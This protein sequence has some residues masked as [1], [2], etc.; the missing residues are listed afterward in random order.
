[1]IGVAVVGAGEWGPNLIRNF[2]EHPRSEVIW[3]VDRDERRLERLGERYPGVRLSTELSEA[4]A[5]AA[6]DAVVVAT[7]TTTHYD[8]ARSALMAGKHALVEK[9]LTASVGE[10]DDLCRLADG[11]GTVL[12]VGHVF[13][14]N[15]AIQRVKQYL[16][17]RSL[18]RVYYISMVRTNLGPIRVDVNAG[19]DLAAHDIAIANWWLEAEPLT[20]SA[21][22]GTWINEGLEDAVFAAFRYPN[23]VLVKLDASWLNP[24]KVRD[25]TIV[26]EH[27]MMTVDDMNLNE[28]LR[29][30]DKGVSNERMVPDFVDTFASFRASTREGDI[31][32]PKVPTGE[33]L[34]AECDHFLSCIE[35]RA[36]PLS[37]GPEGAAV[38][39]ALEAIDRSI[40]SGG[41]EVPVA[42]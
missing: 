35:S 42:L 34:R 26:G 25:I 32:V 20:V 15:E 13:I 2:H 3:L 24:R 4:L 19:W 8:L 10:A 16:V 22:G 7:P 21:V 12:M 18:G 30:Y 5:D 1:V 40:A 39:R 38:V 6:V 37:G 14:Y 17:E 28:P 31:S 29:I 27:R 41:R 33:P 9:P 11:A 23:E 36:R